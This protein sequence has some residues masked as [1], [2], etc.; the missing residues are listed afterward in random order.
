[1][2]LA[3]LHPGLLV[4]GAVLT[5]VPILIHLFFRRRHRV[6]RWAAME[7]LLLALRKQKRRMQMENL[8]LLLLRCAAILLLGLAIARPTT[9]AA[10]LAPLAGSARDVF[11]VID[12]S[13]SMN[14]RQ[15]NVRTIER[16][17]ERAA[18]ALAEMPDGT[19]VTLVATCDDVANGG[20]R[21]LLESA[22]P[23]EARA[24]LAGV[25]AGHGQNRLGDLF[26]ILREKLDAARG[27]A[28][29]HFLTDLQRRDWRDDD[30]ARRDDVFRALRG[31]R[32]GDAAP[33]AVRVHDLS[34]PESGNVTI[35]SFDK[36]EGRELFAGTLAGLTARLVNYTPST[37]SGTISLFVAREDGSFE[38]AVATAIEI[39]PSLDVGPAT[40]ESPTL[41]LPLPAGLAGVA[42]FRLV[43]EPA[44]GRSDRLEEDSVRHL[45]VRIRPPVRFLPILSVR[46]AIDI[47]R[48]VEGLD[49]IEFLEPILP[50]EVERADLSRADVLLWGDAEALDLDPAGA[51]RIEEFVRRG[52]ALLAYLG[53]Y[54]QPGRVN[55]LFYREKGAG[56]FP[57]LLVDAPP[58]TLDGDASPAHFDL[59]EPIAHPLLREM[60]A[61][62]QARAY[63]QSPEILYYRPVRE[64]FEERDV[65]LRFDTPGRDP[66]VLEHS[67]GNGRVLV[68]MTTP[69]ERGFRLNGSLV[70]PVF[71]FEA[72]H[73]LVAEAAGRR[74]ALSGQSLRIPL[75]PATRQVIVEPPEEAGGRTE[76]PIDEPEK[77][78]LLSN[79][80]VPGFYRLL[81]RTSPPAGSGDEPGEE[82]DFAALNLDPAEGDLRPIA[83]EELLRAYAGTSLEIAG[84]EEP[85]ARATPASG[86]EWSRLL[87]LVVAGLLFGELLLAWRFGAR[88]RRTA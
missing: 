52:G 51:R 72:A 35:A 74:N 13:N 87:L 25:R 58:V 7:F 49:V 73:Y 23:S 64:V 81:F 27:T 14:A 26:R 19:R 28:L 54:A 31:L 61:T 66:A 18:E 4:L 9:G 71:F 44:E 22:S 15:A 12:T 45:A 11:L 46:N 85:A 48:D 63:F 10:V 43:F 62:A 70:P 82:V 34:S 38:K 84:R 47:L 17:K 56:L 76:W 88:R 1:M 8:L 77:P 41:Y 30:G 68:V 50:E 65:L 3:L 69:D 79:A 20:P 24:R 78:F 5:S 39:G 53:T 86:G 16:A 60:T 80:V 75:P 42:R 57:M 37:A 83:P 40:A 55:E 6:V 29:V 21:A 67:L 59:K 2:I 33:P 32:A 36:E